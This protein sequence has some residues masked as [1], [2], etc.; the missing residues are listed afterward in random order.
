MSITGYTDI[1][2]GNGV[3][4]EYDDTGK[5]GGDGDNYKAKLYPPSDIIVLGGDQ[6][7]D[8]SKEV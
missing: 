5:H 7:N 8:A 3:H 2:W 1:P 4:R 6:Q